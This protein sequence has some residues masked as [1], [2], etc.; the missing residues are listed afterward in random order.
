MAFER[1][2]APLGEASGASRA[3]IFEAHP[4][5]DGNQLFSPR[6]EGCGW[7]GP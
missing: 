1:L 7:P 3:Y 6:A 4:S 5:P 2:V